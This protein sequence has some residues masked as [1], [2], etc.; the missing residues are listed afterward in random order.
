MS[1]YKILITLKKADVLF[2][3]M[4]KTNI[5][6]KEIVLGKMNLIPTH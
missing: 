6:A 4:R 5:V 1:K 3:L 2:F